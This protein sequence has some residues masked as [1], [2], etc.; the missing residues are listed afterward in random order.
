MKKIIYYIT[1]HGKGHA[2]RS[3]AIIRKL[4]GMG[5]EV[6][7]RNSNVVD[8]LKKSLPNTEI[9]TGMTDVGPVIENNGI[10]INQE[11]SKERIGN[12]L[13]NMNKRVED[14]LKLIYPFNPDLFISDISILPIITAK[15]MGIKSIAISNFTWYDVLKF[16]PSDQL[17][18]IKASYS[19]ADF[20]IKLPI[21]TEMQHFENKLKVGYV[22]RIPTET[23]NEIRKKLGI[24]ESEYVVTFA[25][26]GSKEIINCKIGNRIK[27]LSMNSMIDSSLNPL[28]VSDWIEGQDIVQASDLLICK[29]GYGLI[30][31]CITSGTSF[32][33]IVDKAHQE[34]RS[35]AIELTQKGWGKKIQLHEINQLIID[36]RFL[37]LVP[38]TEKQPNDLDNTVKYIV[39]KF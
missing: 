35:M 13:E 9:I 6:V 25:L 17:E 7:I 14:E 36:E 27:I 39:N 2:T 20:V 28:N 38:R 23:R 15:K 1:D 30:S 32:C 21:G 31:E 4:Q 10:S 37:K 5:I 26:G 8:L 24:A 19:L 18:F 34:Q 11:Q 12:W 29:C 22:S 33:Y 3:I 16:L